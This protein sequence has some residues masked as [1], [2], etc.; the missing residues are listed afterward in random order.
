MEGGIMFAIHL[1][2]F[3]P[4]L[5]NDLRSFTISNQTAISVME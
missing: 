1:E 4:N 5:K 3:P 2:D